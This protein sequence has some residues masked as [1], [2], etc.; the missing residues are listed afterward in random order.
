[1]V[2]SAAKMCDWGAYV[3]QHVLVRGQVFKTL[4]LFCVY[5]Y[6]VPRSQRSP[7]TGVTDM[8]IMRVLDVEPESSA[9]TVLNHWATFL[10]S[11]GQPLWLVSFPPPWHLGME[12]SC[13]FCMEGAFKDYFYVYDSFSCMCACISQVY[14]VL[15]KPEGMRI[16]GIG[17]IDGCN[18]PCEG[19]EVNLGPLQ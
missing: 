4:F 18:P 1:M 19:W 10:A 16:P 13:Q 6:L 15:W 11:R 17:V 8:S 3:P 2:F 9:R 12:L 14:L 7:R 5:E